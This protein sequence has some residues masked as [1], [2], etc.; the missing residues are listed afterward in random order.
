MAKVLLV[1][2][3]LSFFMKRKC[4]NPVNEWWV[5]FDKIGHWFG[6]KNYSRQYSKDIFVEESGVRQQTNSNELGPPGYLDT[7]S[8]LQNFKALWIQV[9]SPDYISNIYSIH[10]WCAHTWTKQY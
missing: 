8:P 3:P 6:F 10:N 1:T 2:F 9:T 7:I 5:P 4:E